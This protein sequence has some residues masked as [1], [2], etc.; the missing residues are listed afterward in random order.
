LP[1]IASREACFLRVQLCWNFFVCVD[2]FYVLILVVP[3][4][5]FDPCHLCL[6]HFC[7]NSCSFRVDLLPLNMVGCICGCMLNGEVVFKHLSQQ[8]DGYQ[9]VLGHKMVC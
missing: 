5:C 9:S 4:S 8:H 7:L 3:V 6:W 2:K 1:R